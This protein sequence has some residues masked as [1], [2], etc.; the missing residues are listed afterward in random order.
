M[1]MSYQENLQ[2]E[3][4]YF[5]KTLS[6]LKTELSKALECFSERRSNLIKSNKEMWEE[7]AHSSCD[8]EKMTEVNQYLMDLTTQS[9]GY[10]NTKNLIEKYRKSL[11]SPYFGRFDFK[12]DGSKI[13]EKFYIGLTSLIDDKAGDVLVY[14]WRAPI[15]SIFYQYEL[16]EASYNSPRGKICGSVTLKRQYK[17]K[18]SELKYFFDCSIKINDEMLQAVLGQNSSVKMRNIVESIQKEQ[19]V[20]IRDTENQLLTVQGVAGSGKTSIALHRIAFLLY[21]GLNSQLKSKNMLIVSPNMTFSKYISSILPELG[22]ENV[23]QITFGNFVLDILKEKASVETRNEQLENLLNGKNKY[24]VEMKRKSMELKEGEIFI[25]ILDRLIYYFERNVIAFEDVY[26]DGKTIFSRHELKDLFLH[27]NKDLPIIKRL[28]RM[29]N[30]IYEKIHS[31]RKERMKKIEKLV[32][33]ME[34]HELEVKSFSR[35]LL[36]KE[37]KAFQR[38]IKK[39]T[40]VDYFK[41]Y[42]F[43]FSQKGLFSKLSVGLK[44]P[45]TFKEIIR[46]TSDTLKRKKLRFEDCP[47][48]LYL[49]LNLEGSDDFHDIKH[50]VIDE[51]QDYSPLQYQVFK[52][53][54]HNA[55]FTVLGDINQSM[56]KEIDE[57][58][59]DDIIKILQK[60][61]AHKLYLNKSYRS[62]YEIVQFSKKLLDKEIKIEALQRHENEPIILEKKKLED[63]DAAIVHETKNLIQGGYESIVILC[64][65]AIEAK[66]IYQR[67]KGQLEVNLLTDSNEEIQKGISIMPIYLSKGLEFDVVFVY[68]ANSENYSNELDRKLLYIAST[69]ALHRLNIYYIGRK[70]RFI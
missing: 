62:S 33:K 16:G 53:L 18:N 43:L 5:M 13:N 66:N 58:I 63:I 67:I 59:Y 48:L 40:D 44:L 24:Q 20:I 56:E 39:M 68:N 23:R 10:F 7:T 69:R 11:N 29:E 65:T 42:Q 38:N 26:Y 54:F 30:K 47:P 12:E 19:D 45:D 15:S 3:F 52:L 28:K 61:K 2:E 37:F 32:K 64:K 6:F 70:S 9:A 27:K 51:A 55:S 21:T 46:I 36:M 22:E 34:G 17:I 50:V 57:K 41:L 1:P 4:A 14:D 31:F 8:F 35:L 25:Q 49:K 60:K